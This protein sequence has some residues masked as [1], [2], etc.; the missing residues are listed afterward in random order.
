MLSNH[1]S[2][3]IDLTPSSVL[4]VTPSLVFPGQRVYMRFSDHAT[5]A[6][7]GLE[8]SADSARQLAAALVAKLMKGVQHEL[9]K[10]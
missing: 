9:P 10:V 1:T 8:L 2:T 3:R 6:S 7:F 4:T 5:W